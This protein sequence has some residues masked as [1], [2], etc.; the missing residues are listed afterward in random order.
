MSAVNN[1]WRLQ[2][3]K[4]NLSL[5]LSIIFTGILG[6]IL[7]YIGSLIAISTDLKNHLSTSPNWQIMLYVG[8]F[9]FTS[10]TISLFYAEKTIDKKLRSISISVPWMIFVSFVALTATLLSLYFILG[11]Y[12]LYLYET[13]WC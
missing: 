6:L 4:A 13:F 11:S 12:S 2:T 3:T 5:S 8:V 7:S 1:D 10:L 9:V